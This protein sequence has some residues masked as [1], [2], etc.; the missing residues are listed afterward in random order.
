[1]RLHRIYRDITGGEEIPIIVVS[2]AGAITRSMET[3]GVR[4][5]L[6]KPFEVAELTDAVDELVG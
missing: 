5:S 4:R 6:R 3:A 1:M 2:A